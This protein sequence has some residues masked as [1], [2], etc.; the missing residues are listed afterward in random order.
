MRTVHL[1]WDPAADRFT[2]VGSHP[3]HVIPIN[4][5]RDNPDAPATGFSAAELLLAAAGACAAWDVVEILR[6]QRQE[7]HGINV[8]VDGEQD[9]VPPHG[10]RKL[11]L[12]F[13]FRGSGLVEENLRRVVRLSIDRYC[14]VI[15]TL[16]GRAEIAE[17]IEV[18]DTDR[19][20]D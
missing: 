1:T 13:T 3:E 7:I 5:P 16:R 2:A 6:K 11:T 14:S 19:P 20:I 12:R 10:Y 15:D 4:A 17:E 18:V 8:T 9:S